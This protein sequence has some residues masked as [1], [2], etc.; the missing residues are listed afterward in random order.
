MIENLSSLEAVDNLSIREFSDDGGRTFV[1]DF[2]PQATDLEVDVVD[3][4]MIVFAPG[5]DD[6]VDVELPPGEARTFI[7][8]GVLTIEV[9][10]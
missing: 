5:R 10:E 9:E 4:T 6:Q 3:G 8:N 7:K 2:G 1:V